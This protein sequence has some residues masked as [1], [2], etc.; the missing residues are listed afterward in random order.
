MWHTATALA[1]KHGLYM[2]PQIS[3]AGPGPLVVGAS[4][5]SS[6]QKIMQGGND[7]VVVEHWLFVCASQNAV[8]E[9]AHEQPDEGTTQRKSGTRDE[10]ADICCTRPP[11]KKN[12][13]CGDAR[14]F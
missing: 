13:F 1:R 3:P 9:A 6:G 11:L 14:D 7:F 10:R 12:S 8:L 4:P 5:R 2:P